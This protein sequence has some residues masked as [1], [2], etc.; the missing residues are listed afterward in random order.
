MDYIIQLLSSKTIGTLVVTALSSIL[1]AV[2]GQDAGLTADQQTTLI[3]G[4][5]TAGSVLAGVFRARAST[6]IGTPK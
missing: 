3:A 6:V 4:I 1:T 2:Y 5:A